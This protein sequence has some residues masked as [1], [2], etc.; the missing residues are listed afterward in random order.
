MANKFLKD[1][2]GV[3]YLKQKFINNL[4][5]K[6]KKSLAE[7]VFNDMVNELARRSKK[8]GMEVF[9]KAVENV[10]PMLEVKSRRIGGATYQVPIEVSHARQL[11]LA[12]RWILGYAKARKENDMA[13]RLAAEL[14][15]AYNKEGSSI[16]KREDT[17]KMAEANRAFAHYRW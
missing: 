3:D 9:E 11:T 12:L 5:I 8:D 6:G 14:M 10:K 2:R 4:L 1:L 13:L 7:R 17:H 15:D 16:K